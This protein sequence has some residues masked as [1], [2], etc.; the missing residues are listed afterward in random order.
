M[1]TFWSISAFL[2][3]VLAVAR[4][5]ESV[6]VLTTDNFDK[7]I[8][9]SKDALVEFYAPAEFKPIY[10]QLAVAYQPFKDRVLIASVDADAHKSLGTKYGVSG[11]PTIKWF[12]KGSS[13]PEDYSGGREVTDFINFIGE[14]SGVN[15]IIKT[16]VTAV[17]VL[18]SGNFYNY[19]G[20]DKNVLVEFYA[21][22]CG[23]CKTLAPTYEKVAKDFSQESD[24]VVANVDATAATDLAEKYRVE[25]FPTIKFFPK[26]AKESPVEYT[27]GRSEEDFLAYLNEKCGTHRTVGGGLDENA[28]QVAQMAEYVK[29]FLSR[30][31]K[32]FREAVIE[33]AKIAASELTGTVKSNA[34]YYVKFMEKIVKSGENYIETEY[35]RLEKLGK[36]ATVEQADS[37]SLRKNILGLFRAAGLVDGKE[38]L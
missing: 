12:P 22:W 24:C 16:P 9:G 30:K 37:F 34:A 38:E 13:T 8:D 36:A 14:K 23:H 1:R 26:G 17:T 21:P 20:T 6:L 35:K 33:E 10:E 5:D 25:G 28:G 11:Y 15:P 2:A 4:A 27:A 3:A 18:T 7:F 32:K 31:E 29:K 19:V